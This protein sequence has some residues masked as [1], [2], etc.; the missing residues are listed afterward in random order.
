[1][2]IYD[3]LYNEWKDNRMKT[4]NGTKQPGAET[5]KERYLRCFGVRTDNAAALQ[6]IVK[7]LIDEGV[8]R[9]TLVSWAVQAGYTKGYVS[10][11]LSRILCSIGLRERR[12]GAG[13]KPS[14]A[15]LELM[16]YAQDKYGEQFLKVLRAAWRAGKAQATAQNFLA[17]PQSRADMELILAPQLQNRRGY[18]GATIK[19]DRKATVRSGASLYQ[20]AGI[21]FK[22]NFNKTTTARTTIRRK[23]L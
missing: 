3:W 22:R 23:Q 6:E 14:P 8:S 19:H 13:R 4:K 20:P 15:A 9:Q 11:L 2:G 21:I 7:G 1:M 5:L 12:P 17:T 10:S 18:L 16:V